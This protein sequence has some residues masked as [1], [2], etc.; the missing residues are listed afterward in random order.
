MYNIMPVLST[1]SIR[2]PEEGK[3]SIR[4]VTNGQ[5]RNKSTKEINAEDNLRMRNRNRMMT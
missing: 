5:T 4:S 2:V 1:N 3:T